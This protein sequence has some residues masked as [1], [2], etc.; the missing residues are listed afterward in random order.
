[1]NYNVKKNKQ[2]QS[3]YA[4]NL[5]FYIKFNLFY[6]RTLPSKPKSYG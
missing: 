1:M 2:M 6:G 3:N 4:Y 5:N